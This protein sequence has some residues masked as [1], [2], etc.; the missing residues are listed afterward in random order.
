MRLGVEAVAD[1][2]RR[3]REEGGCK[4]AVTMEVE[5]EVEE[6]KAMVGIA[7]PSSKEGLGRFGWLP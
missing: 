1:G 5:V 6:E 3:D 2:L 4:R 7:G